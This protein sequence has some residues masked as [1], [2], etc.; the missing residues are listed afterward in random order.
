MGSIDCWS[1][2]HVR[3]PSCRLVVV[4]P[5][6]LHVLFLLRSC[7]VASVRLRRSRQTQAQLPNWHSC[8]VIGKYQPIAARLAILILLIID[9]PDD[10]TVRFRQPGKSVVLPIVADLP[11]QTACILCHCSLHLKHSVASTAALYPQQVPIAIL[12]ARS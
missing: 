1:S 8:L 6:S 10:S 2:R 3:Y 5:H 4:C 12:D 7:S 11:R 9:R